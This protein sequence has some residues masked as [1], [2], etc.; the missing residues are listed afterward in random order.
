MLCVPRNLKGNR[1]AFAGTED[2]FTDMFDCSDAVNSLL[3]GLNGWSNDLDDLRHPTLECLDLFA[4]RHPSLN[5]RPESPPYRSTL[6][7]VKTAAVMIFAHQGGWDELALVALPLLVIAVLLIIANKRV[8]A[9]LDDA[10][11]SESNPD[12]P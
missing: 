6:A 7:F 1:G 2:L 11:N 9:K 3:D 12:S 10:Q 8:S 5:P 4:H